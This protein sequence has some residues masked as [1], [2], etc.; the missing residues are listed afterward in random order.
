MSS[1]RSRSSAPPARRASSMRPSSELSG[2]R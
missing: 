2:T 1:P